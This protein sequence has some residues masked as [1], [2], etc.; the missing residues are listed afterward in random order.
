MFIKQSGIDDGSGDHRQLLLDNLTY[1]T[2]Y[3]KAKHLFYDQPISDHSLDRFIDQLALGDGRTC[4]VKFNPWDGYL[5]TIPVDQTAFPHR[6][7]KFG[8]QFMVY[9]Q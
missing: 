3:F 7:Y 4:H 2:Y 9:P 6:H 1:P 5:S 8:I